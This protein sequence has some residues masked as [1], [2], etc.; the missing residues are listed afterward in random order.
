[1]LLLVDVKPGYYTGSLLNLFSYALL[2]FFIN[3]S[4]QHGYH[5]RYQVKTQL[6]LLSYLH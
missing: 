4:D 6:K 2:P 3:A 1:M 5:C